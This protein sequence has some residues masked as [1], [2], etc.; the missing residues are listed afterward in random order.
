MARVN[1]GFGISNISGKIGGSVHSRTAYGSVIRDRPH[2]TANDSP[3]QLIQRSKLF[4]VVLEWSKLT[5]TQRQEW[6][7]YS[8]FYNGFPHRSGTTRLNGYSVFCLLNLNLALAVYPKLTRP[9]WLDT[10]Y[11][12]TLISVDYAA[13]LLRVTFSPAIDVTLFK[14]VIYSCP[15][16]SPGIGNAD[17]YY[18]FVP[19]DSVT[20]TTATFTTNYLSRFGVHPP[21]GRSLFVAFSI[22]EKATG[23]D[24]QELE[25]KIICAI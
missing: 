4:N 3:S 9:A 19:N 20:V 18:K 2:H 10:T 8:E 22:I 6:N 11:N 15:P 5:E 24:T 17:P 16:L 23:Y 14:P 25:Q 12:L 21:V 13:N 1:Y 7:S